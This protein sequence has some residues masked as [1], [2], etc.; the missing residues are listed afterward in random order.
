MNYKFTFAKTVVELEVDLSE[1]GTISDSYCKTRTERGSEYII[2]LR[3][4]V[5]GTWSLSW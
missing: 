1:V 3:E 4:R 2:Y 5:S